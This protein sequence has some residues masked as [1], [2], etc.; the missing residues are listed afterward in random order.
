MSKKLYAGY[1]R[2]SGKSQQTNSS[3]KNQID[4]IKAYAK[5]NNIKVDLFQDV[6][7]GKNTE[8]TNFNIMMSNIDSYAGVIC[9][10]LDRISRDIIDTLTIKKQL[11]LMGK[12][13]IVINDSM[14]KDTSRL[15]L[16]I[17]ALISD[18][19]RLTI[20][21]RMLDGKNKKKEQGYI[22]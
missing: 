10:K 3:I 5:T 1:I 12:E 18:E 4:T 7:S 15:E 22:S 21:K 2:I 13:L 6:A 14:G 11:D 17:R 16:T 9:L 8:R 20:N 19:E